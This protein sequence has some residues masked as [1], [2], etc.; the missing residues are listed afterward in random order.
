MTRM[1]KSVVTIVYV[2]IAG[3]TGAGQAPADTPPRGGFG[4]EIQPV[5]VKSSRGAVVHYQL[6][7]RAERTAVF[8][9]GVRARVRQTGGATSTV[10]DAFVTD[11]SLR[12]GRRVRVRLR[13]VSRRGE[14]IRRD[15]RLFLHRRFPGPRAMQTTRISLARQVVDGSGERVRGRVLLQTPV[16]LLRRT[17]RDASPTARFAASLGG[18]CTAKV[19]VS[20]RALATREGPT[21]LVRA[22]TAFVD[23]V[24]AGGARAGGAWR[25]V[26]FRYTDPDTGVQTRPET[27]YGIAAVTLAP[28]RSFQVRVFTDFSQ[29]CTETQRRA[30]PVAAA[31][32]SLLRTARVQAR[33]VG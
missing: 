17:N 18:A 20:S 21:A 5:A 26:A 2:L 28:R 27:L 15:E 6:N 3:A 31:L 7:R 11:R 22:S 13:I 32:R 29:A 19:A 4:F 14:V 8:V 24:L 9:A 10:Y 33:L 1:R 12:S 16:W 25:V 23:A 30:G